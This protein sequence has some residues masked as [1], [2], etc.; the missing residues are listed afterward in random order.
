MSETKKYIL[1][2]PSNMDKVSHLLHKSKGNVASSTTPNTTERLAPIKQR[3]TYNLDTK[4]L[5]IVNN[6][7]LTKEQKVQAYNQAL[8]EFKSLITDKQSAS[9]SVAQSKK[10]TN[11]DENVTKL[12]PDANPLLS[13]V[14][15]KFQR[16][17]SILLKYLVDSKKLEITPSGNV[18]IGGKRVHDSNIT[19]LINRSVNPA[20]PRYHIPGWE[21]FQTLLRETNAPLL[22]LSS[23]ITKAGRS[24][25]SP[26]LNSS[27]STSTPRVESSISNWSQHDSKATPKRKKRH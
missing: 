8:I 17:A 24:T 1:L 4:M 2:D 23:Q 9:V 19:D 16:K 21:S 5:D 7:I 20:T 25:E 18:I 27:H 26:P 22:L 13:G 14:S 11:H 10:E 15:T 6:D 12:A 3:E